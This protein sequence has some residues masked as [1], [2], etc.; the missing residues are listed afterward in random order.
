MFNPITHVIGVDPGLVHTGLV[1]M[2][3]DRTTRSVTVTHTV[4]QGGQ[5]SRAQAWCLRVPTTTAKP[6]TFIEGYRPRSHYGTD[7]R[8]VEEVAMLRGALPNT[9]VLPNTGVKKVIKKDLME[10]LGV[11]KF[12]TVTHHQDLRSAARIAL[13]GMVKDDEMN[14]VLA[15]V[16]Y[17]HTRGRTWSVIG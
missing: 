9:T 11:W 3:F 16:V 2:I 17:D 14:R 6:S 10:L 12:S 8:M 15:D 13:F 5:V 4:V 7:T 1:R